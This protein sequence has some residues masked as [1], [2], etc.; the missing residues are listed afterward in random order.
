[1]G[2]EFAEWLSSQLPHQSCES[3]ISIISHQCLSKKPFGVVQ[4]QLIAD[5]IEDGI[6]GVFCLGNF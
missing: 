5:S 6:K 2:L 1:L 4:R 3:V